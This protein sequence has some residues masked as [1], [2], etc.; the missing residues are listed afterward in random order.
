[1]LLTS[2]EHAPEVDI[3]NVVVISAAGEGTS[4]AVTVPARHVG[5]KPGLA[6]SA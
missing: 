6:E 4:V 3:T 2:V 1:V 5:G